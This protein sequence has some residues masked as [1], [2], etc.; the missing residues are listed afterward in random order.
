MQS[1]RHAARAFLGVAMTVDDV[2]DRGR[3]AYGR[4]S[5]GGLFSLLTAADRDAPLGNDVLERLA[6]G[7]MR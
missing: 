1:G 3:D 4:R 6:E 2:L 7:G 5:W